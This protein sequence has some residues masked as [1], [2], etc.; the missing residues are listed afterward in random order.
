[1]KPRAQDKKKL[2]TAPRQAKSDERRAHARRVEKKR[3]AVYK[4]FRAAIAKPWKIQVMPD[5]KLANWII[6]AT[7]APNPVDVPVYGTVSLTA[8]LPLDATPRDVR[9]A[10]FDMGCLVPRIEWVQSGDPRMRKAER[11]ADELLALNSPRRA[12]S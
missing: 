8:I 5:E 4:L 1:M 12:R 10:L 2:Q 11:A 6:R 3:R 7:C 9:S